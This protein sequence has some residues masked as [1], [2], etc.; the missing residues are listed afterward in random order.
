M[1]QRL[2]GSIS[3]EETGGVVRLLRIQLPKLEGKPC[4]LV[5]LRMGGGISMLLRT[6][7]GTL[8]ADERTTIAAS[9]HL[10]ETIEAF[11]KKLYNY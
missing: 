4:E 7:G 1:A 3:E 8:Y 11:K 2:Q 6:G 9:M 5:A 10:D